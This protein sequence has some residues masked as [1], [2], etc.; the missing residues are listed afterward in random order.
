[1][2]EATGV[3]VQ[4]EK[5]AMFS[6]KWE[7]YEIVEVPMDTK[8]NDEVI[9]WINMRNSVKTLGVY[10]SKRLSKNDEFVYAKKKMK[11]LLKS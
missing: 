8:I 2:Q 3:K 11:N 4:K 10:V 5:F 1:M 7:I 6:W 9:K